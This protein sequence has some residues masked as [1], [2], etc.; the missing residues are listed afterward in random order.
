[1]PLSFEWDDEKAASSLRK[2]G[3]PFEYAAR[4]FLDVRRCDWEDDRKD[5]GEERRITVGYVDE[6]LL[7]VTYTEQGEQ[8]IRLISARKATRHEQESHHDHLSA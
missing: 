6:R 7:V 3:I 2:H 8:T 1:M 4:V 5:Y